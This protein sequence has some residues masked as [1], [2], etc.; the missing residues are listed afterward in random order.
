VRVRRAPGLIAAP[1]DG[2]CNGQE[3]PIPICPTRSRAAAHRA[4]L[5]ARGLRLA[6]IRVPDTRAP[7]FAA[8]ARRQARR[9]DARPG[10]DDTMEFLER[11]SMFDDEPGAP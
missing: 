3:R 11:V 2:P 6:R 4:A 9:V 10:F 7:G 1:Q 8:E 5:R